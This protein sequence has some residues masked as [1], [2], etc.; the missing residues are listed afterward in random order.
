[1]CC[2]HHAL[3]GEPRPPVDGMVERVVVELAGRAVWA[4]LVLSRSTHGRLPPPA[5]THASNSLLRA[6]S[7]EPSLWTGIRP[8]LINEYTR[9]RGASMY[10]AIRSAPRSQPSSVV[11]AERAASRGASSPASWSSASSSSASSSAW[12]R[13]ALTTTPL[14]VLWLRR[15]RR[16]GTRGQVLGGRWSRSRYLVSRSHIETGPWD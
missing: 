14:H 11:V 2:S 1:M 7:A 3:L 16:R 10:S 8:A 12:A 13:G 4:G 5:R 9:D 6:T 15:G